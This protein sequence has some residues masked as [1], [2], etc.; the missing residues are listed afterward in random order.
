M[1][2]PH[3]PKID[4]VRSGPPL[5]KGELDIKYSQL[6]RSLYYFYILRSLT[7]ERHQDIKLTKID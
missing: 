1:I 5:T 7:L 6:G 2:N 4:M 3:E